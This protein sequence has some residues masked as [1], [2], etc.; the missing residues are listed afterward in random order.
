[1]ERKKQCRKCINK[2]IRKYQKEY[3]KKN[4]KKLKEIYK[5]R[6]IDKKKWRAHSKVRIAIKRGLLKKS[7]CVVCG[8]TYRV[9]GHHLDY[10]K[11]LEV[12]WLCSLHHCKTHSMRKDKPGRPPKN[13]YLKE[14]IQEFRDKNLSYAEIGKEMGM[15]RQLVQY[16]YYRKLST[17]Q[18]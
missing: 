8:T 6:K 10:S 16:Y 15:S 7:P 17:G 12:V 11:P 2:R 18:K 3:F 13:L 4:P 14:K 1:M 9:H 5:R